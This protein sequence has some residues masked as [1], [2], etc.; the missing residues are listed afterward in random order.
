MDASVEAVVI[1][2]GEHYQGVRMWK[3]SAIWPNLTRLCILAS[4]E[5]HLEAHENFGKYYGHDF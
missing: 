2:M 1:E 5:A 4:N 3:K